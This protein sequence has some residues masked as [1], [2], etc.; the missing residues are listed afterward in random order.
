[1]SPSLWCRCALYR[2]SRGTFGGDAF[3]LPVGSYLMRLDVPQLA[4]SLRLDPASNPK[5]PE[6]AID[7]ASRESSERVETRRVARSSRAARVRY[8]GPRVCRFRGRPIGAIAAHAKQSGRPASSRLSLWDQPA[9]LLLF[10]G[11]LTVEWVAR[12]RWGLP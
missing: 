5:V 10:V 11:I 8:Q 2:G 1:M 9:F 4:D 3:S 6:A 7:V 12:K